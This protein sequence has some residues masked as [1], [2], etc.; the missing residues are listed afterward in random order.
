[1]KDGSSMEEPQDAAE[2]ATRKRSRKP[3]SAAVASKRSKSGK[4]PYLLHSI[5]LVLLPVRV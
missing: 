3:S 5:I 2:A 1:M 4:D